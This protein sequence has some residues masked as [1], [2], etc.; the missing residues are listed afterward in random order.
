[1]GAI[2]K[3]N[4]TDRET[5]RSWIWRQQISGEFGTGFRGGPSLSIMGDTSQSLSDYDLPHLIM[6]YTALLSLAILRDGFSQL[7]RSGLIK[8]LHAS[9][10]PDG[11]FSPVPGSTEADIRPLYCAFSICHMLND[12]SGIDVRAAI[13][14]IQ[15][16]RTYEG[17]YSQSPDQEA[18]GGTTYCAIA[19]LALLPLAIRS[20]TA[21]TPFELKQTL[22]WLALM[23]E[24][25][26]AG[27]FK[28]RTEKTADACYSFWCGATLENLNAGHLVDPDAN[29]R[30]I[31]SCQFKYGGIAKA[32]NHPPD[33][34]H[35]YMSLASLAIYPPTGVAEPDAW[36]LQKMDP[37]LNASRDTAEWA[38]EKIR[39]TE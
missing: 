2:D 25:T 6:T 4:T 23:Q 39:A 20:T 17:G 3:T 33:P 19:A 5:W 9:Q 1:M 7:D 16:C 34:L 38:R 29:A 15:R 22:R 35:T 11:S 31:S 28:G 14:Y 21:L 24:P 8:F 26:D 10:L 32:P 36:V 18:S 37:A 12:W 30:F 13:S 27:G